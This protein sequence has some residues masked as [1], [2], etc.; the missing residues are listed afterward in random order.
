[1]AERQSNGGD[2]FP[3]WFTIMVTSVLL[4]GFMYN[5]VANGIEGVAMAGVIASLMGVYAGAD[6]LT[7][8]RKQRDREDG[9][10]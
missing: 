6:R 1:M 7:A 5:L 2:G 3:L 8:L 9:G 4:A 10:T